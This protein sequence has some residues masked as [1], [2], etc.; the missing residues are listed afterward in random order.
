[1]D[2]ESLGRVENDDKIIYG[3]RLN[4][5]KGLRDIISIYTFEK[6]G[7]T[8]V[9]NVE[10]DFKIKSFFGRIM[11][12]MVRKMLRKQTEDGLTKLKKVSEKNGA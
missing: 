3:E 6:K 12:S 4:E 5:F 7:D 11:K 9:V 1:M 8:T 10:V 2:I